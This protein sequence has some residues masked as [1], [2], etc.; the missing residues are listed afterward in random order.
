MLR[1]PHLSRKIWL[2]N[3]GISNLQF[4]TS[5]HLKNLE[6]LKRKNEFDFKEGDNVHGFIVNE[7]LQFMKC[8]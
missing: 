3:R 8:F 7:K 6:D 1:F 2:Q 5:C 4:S